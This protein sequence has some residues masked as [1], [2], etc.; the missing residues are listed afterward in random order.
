M[1]QVDARN[2]HEFIGQNVI[3]QGWV[4]RIRDM[5]GF[6]FLLLRDPWD[7]IQIVVSDP[8]KVREIPLESAVAVSGLV[9]EE[10][11]APLGLEVHLQE[12][13]VL[14]K[15][16]EALPLSSIRRI[17]MPVC[18][19]ILDHRALSLRHPKERAIFVFKQN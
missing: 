18:S 19:L 5:G 13:V 2:I 15:A 9:V 12:I 16:L 11:R 4:H 6:A 7:I 1:P 3:L 17:W 10:P 8:Q 14:S